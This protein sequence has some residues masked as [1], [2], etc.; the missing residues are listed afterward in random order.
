MMSRTVSWGVLSTAR[1]GTEKVIPAMQR[2]AVSRVAA[3]ASR[4]KAR[5]EA[6]A[7]ELGIPR[8]YGSYEELLA[9]PAIEAIYNALP[10]HLHVPW[11]IRALQAGKHVLCEK[12]IALSAEEAATLIAAREQTGKLVAEAFMV[13]HHPQW[14]KAREIARSG[15]VGDVRAMQTYFSYHLTDP[16][17]V[18]NQADIG[19]GGLYDIGCYAILTARYIFGAEPERV[20]ASFERDPAMGIDRVTSGL[21]EFPG[22]RQ[23]SF[24]CA[25]QLVLGQRVQILGTTGRIEVAVPFNA[26]ANKA[27]RL[28]VDD[29][30]DVEGS[31]VTVEEIAPCDQYTLQGDAFSR[32]VLGEAPLEWPIED[33]VLTMRVI[34]AYFR[35]GLSGRWEKP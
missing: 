31:G 1:I 32:A 30:R 9:D 7:R 19:G 34:D 18:R 21:A 24:L 25:T 29:G 26:P 14:Q 10:N 22:G 6:V 33:A 11:T 23:L 27:T 3:I 8:S 15:R 28:L 5:G 16:S 35:S 2:G 13:R 12:P 4:D 20:I 17:N